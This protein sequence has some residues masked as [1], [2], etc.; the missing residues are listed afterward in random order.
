MKAIIISLIT[1]GVIVLTL[2]I[3]F[4]YIYRLIKPSEKETD[5]FYS[6]SCHK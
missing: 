5:D 6:R 2:F 4:I 1:V 3:G